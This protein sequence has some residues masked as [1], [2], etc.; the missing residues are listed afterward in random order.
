VPARAQGDIAP[1]D[2][3][4]KEASR[5]QNDI[6]GAAGGLR[7]LAR[8]ELQEFAAHPPAVPD[9]GE[10][11]RRVTLLVKTF[12]RPRCASRVVCSIRRHFPRVEV[13]VCDDSREPLFED[14]AQPLPGVTWLTLD[15]DRGHTLGAG[16]NYLVD[17]TPTP[18]FFLLDDDHVVTAGTRLADML[19]FLEGH[20]YDIV[21]GAQGREEYGAAVFEQDGDGV[22]QVFHRHHGEVA[23]GV[24]RCDRVSNTFMARTEAVQ[25]VRWE[26]RVYANEHADFFLRASR[27]GLLIA[28]MGG[29]WVDHDRRC[30]QAAGLW[31]R[32][33]G[34]L[35]PHKDGHYRFLRLGGDG[36]TRAAARRAR[37]LYRR[38]VLEKNG[39]RDIVD[40]DRA[41]D[42]RALLRLIGPPDPARR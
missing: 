42:R 31:G 33:L 27:A 26:E 36:Q 37:E 40:V 11:S 14:G 38:Y 24:V 39:V 32:L 25:R 7:A 35:L 2:Q 16:R 41:R 4:R 23:P 1:E 6:A 9:E 8:R 17:R 13:L 5:S 20:G 10:W 22:R 28:Q 29:T 15:F 19:D 30:E 3:V 34:D 18:F 12:E 21:G